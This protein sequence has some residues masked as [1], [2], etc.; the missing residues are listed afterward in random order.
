MSDTN[1]WHSPDERRILAGL[2]RVIGADREEHAFR[3]GELG[4]L[5]HWE[6]RPLEYGSEPER[7]EEQLDYESLKKGITR[8]LADQKRVDAAL[9]R[10]SERKLIT[11]TR[12]STIRDVVIVTLTLEGDDCGR[13][14]SSPRLRLDLWLR[15]HKDY[16]VFLPLGHVVSYVGGVLTA[17]L[18]A[19]LHFW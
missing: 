2:Y 18:A 5:L 13:R 6:S 11:L 16:W 12:H 9:R 14:Y 4:R 3:T 1:L 7:V 10:L 17:A 19:A 15:T 8:F